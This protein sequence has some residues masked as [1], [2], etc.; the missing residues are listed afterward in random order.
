MDSH[1]PT[2]QA[3]KRLKQSD[4]SSP[5]L[6]LWRD[7]HA[8]CTHCRMVWMVLEEK[9][10][11]YIVETVNLYS[12]GRKRLDFLAPH[13]SPKGTVP[14]VQIGKE[15]LLGS[16]DKTVDEML[17]CL[18]DPG[19]VEKW[20]LESDRNLLPSG[21]SRGEAKKRAWSLL[22]L[23]RELWARDQDWLRE[24]EGKGKG[25]DKVGK[26]S[27]KSVTNEQDKDNQ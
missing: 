4:S 23:R 10:F 17:M 11:P 16:A 14:V 13:L 9:K 6:T 21:P 18:E 15:V 27:G 22:G 5:Q 1:P 25:K 3:R 24:E 12:Y 19:E 7:T 2:A 8:W 20:V 26:A